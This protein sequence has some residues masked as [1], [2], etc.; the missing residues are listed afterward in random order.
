MENKLVIG[1]YVIKHHPAKPILEAIANARFETLEE[2]LHTTKNIESI[3]TQ[4][5]RMIGMPVWKS[6]VT[7]V[8]DESGMYKYSIGLDVDTSG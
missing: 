6:K 4:A 1:G 3:V 5:T 8:Q 7:L 2:C